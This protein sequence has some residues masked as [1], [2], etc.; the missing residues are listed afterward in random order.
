LCYNCAYFPTQFMETSSQRAA[1][2]SCTYDRHSATHVML[3]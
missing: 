2:A 1:D 3:G